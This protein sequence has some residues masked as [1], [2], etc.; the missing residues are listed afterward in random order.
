MNLPHVATLKKHKN[1]VAT[2]CLSNQYCSIPLFQSND[3]ADS[4]CIRQLKA[5][6]MEEIEI[7]EVFYKTFL[8]INKQKPIRDI[9]TISMIINPDLERRFNEKRNEMYSKVGEGVW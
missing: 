5:G 2:Y 7:L 6:S 3:F 9:T 8:D 1:L 4:D